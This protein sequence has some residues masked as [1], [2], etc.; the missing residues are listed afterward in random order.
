VFVIASLS[1]Y[2]V[3]QTWDVWV[4]H[5]IRDHFIS[6]P[7]GAR[8]RWIWNNGSTMTSQVFDTLI[9]IGIA[10]GLGFGMLFDPVSRVQLLAMMVG[11]YLCKF[12]LA[13]IDTPFFY[14]LTRRSSSI[15][16]VDER[17]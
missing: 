12:I 3:A 17:S 9:F 2:L 7:D 5:R 10:F 1:A 4:F 6:K 8:H 15:R 11:Q 13:A 16:S 14:L